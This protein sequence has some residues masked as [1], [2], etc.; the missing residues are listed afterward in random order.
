MIICECNNDLI[1]SDNA[2]ACNTF[3]VNFQ[4]SLNADRMYPSGLVSSVNCMPGF[5]NSTHRQRPPP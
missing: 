5:V 1:I 4:I 2:A 3:S